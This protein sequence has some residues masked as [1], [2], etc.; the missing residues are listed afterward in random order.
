[1]NYYTKHSF[2]EYQLRLQ[3]LQA[4]SLEELVSVHACLAAGEVVHEN[5]EHEDHNDGKDLKSSQREVMRSERQNQSHCHKSRPNMPSRTF[6]A[7]S[8]GKDTL[9]ALKNSETAYSFGSSCPNYLTPPG[10]VFTIF[11]RPRF[12]WRALRDEGGGRPSS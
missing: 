5:Q 6:V 4:R 3:L 1:M 10:A 2:L 9:K 11:S 8:R 12:A 7:Q